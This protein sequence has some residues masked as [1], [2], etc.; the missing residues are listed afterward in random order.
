MLEVVSPF[1]WNS[2]VR[3]KLQAQGPNSQVSY[4]EPEDLDFTANI[5]VFWNELCPENGAV[6]KYT[7]YCTASYPRK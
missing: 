2:P 6:D 5:I 4:R 3:W 7:S 1:L